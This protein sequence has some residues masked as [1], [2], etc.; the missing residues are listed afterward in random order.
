[1]R[2]EESSEK[3]GER[4]KVRGQWQGER[5]VARRHAM[6]GPA[7]V[8]PPACKPKLSGGKSLHGL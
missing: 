8:H 3:R 4:S 7:A 2:G 1:M 6:C 5:R